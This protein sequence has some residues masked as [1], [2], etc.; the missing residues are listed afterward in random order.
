MTISA[1]VPSSVQ[2]CALARSIVKG[3]LGN[4]RVQPSPLAVDRVGSEDEELIG[5]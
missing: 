4:G 2:V 1:R 3:R 5:T